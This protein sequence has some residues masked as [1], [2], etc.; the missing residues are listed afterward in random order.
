MF[1]SIRARMIVLRVL[2]ITFFAAA[3]IGLLVLDINSAASLFAEKEESAKV[4]LGKSVKLMGNRLEALAFDYS[5][6]DEMIE[7]VSTGNRKWAAQNIDTAL[8]TFKANA[9]WVYRTD[10]SLVYSVNDLKDKTLSQLPLPKEAFG[11][12]F[13]SGYFQ[14]F[15][16]NTDKGPME[17]RTAPIQP[18][19]DA[20]R[21]TSPQGYFLVGR[22]WDKVVTD[23]IASILESSAAILPAAPEE[24][25]DLKKSLFAFSMPLPGWDGAALN[26]LRVQKYCPTIAAFSQSIYRKYFVFLIFAFVFLLIPSIFLDRWVSDPLKLISKS[27]DAGDPKFVRDL[28]NDEAEFGH[29]ARLVTRSFSEKSALSKEV[30][31]RLKAE[32]ELGGKV[33]ELEDFHDVTVGREL[34]LIELRKE[35]DTLL[36]ELGRPSKY[37]T[38]EAA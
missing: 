23:D 8:P 29:L 28:E 25:H 6:W 17:I 14:R 38:E 18:S 36:K 10:F 26:Y 2:L 5:F 22:L 20:A 16:V 33:K 21:K 7:F 1:T 35:I 12:I 32:K 19:G 3:I 4:L 13:K 37:K 24:I 31:E 30:A 34:N 15:F 11:K 9:A 27:L